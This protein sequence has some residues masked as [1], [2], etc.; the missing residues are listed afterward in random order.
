M[1]VDHYRLVAPL[2]RSTLGAIP[3]VSACYHDGIDKSETWVGALRNPPHIATVSVP[4]PSGPQPYL[5]LEPTAME[6]ATY[7]LHAVE[8]HSWSCTPNDPERMAFARILL[9]SN[10]N[11]P[12][13]LAAQYVRDAL[14]VH[15]LQAIP[16]FDGGGGIALWVPIDDAPAY[17]PVRTWLHTF[18][19]ALA[20]AHPDLI[21]TE[22]NTRGAHLVHLH[23]AKNAPRT[24]SVLP[25]S[26][27]ANP[28]YPVSF[29]ATWDELPTL[30]NGAFTIATL[31]HRLKTVGDLFATLRSSIPEQSFARISPI[32]MSVSTDTQAGPHHVITAALTILADGIPRS[33]EMLCEAAI[34][35]HL[36][37]PNFNP[38]YLYTAL[39]EYITRANGNARK[40]RILQNADRSF[41]L[42]EP[43]DDW[44][45]LV[46][47]PAA[48][49]PDAATLALIARLRATSTGGNPTAFE[50]AVCDTFSH[51]GFLA[52]HLG[53]EK[54]PDGYADAPLGILRYRLMIECK[55]AS[56]DV[57]QPN[58]FEASKYRDAYTAQ[59]CTLVGPAFANDTQLISELQTHNVS[60]WTVDDLATILTVNANPYEI[61]ALLAPGFAADSIVD[62]VWNRVHGLAKRMR[63]I[64]HLIHTEGWHFQ[65]SAIN[66]DPSV[67]APQI[68]IDV[69]LAL[70]DEALSNAGATH[71]CTRDEIIQAF[72]Y[73]TNPL[74]NIATSPTQN[75]IILT[76]SPC[77]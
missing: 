73:L 60:A 33:A 61:T 42:N 49:T 26:A 48:P 22:P 52:T 40:P 50:T 19:A 1:L 27:R 17:D 65:T 31:P 13:I 57:A 24:F 56:S 3:I 59:Y 32:V 5:A 36:L 66:D 14:N 39:I 20:V 44:P 70:V 34:A 9:E 53:G 45:D 25:Y 4:T 68:T 2:L 8:F 58:C 74:L 67:P 10:D 29:P 63:I 47:I 55:T 7:A 69:A 15:Q 6:W 41:R 71:G 46:P 64:T 38:K 21:T 23:V 76:R 11:A 18:A 62:L 16:V 35:A 30:H 28:H 72:A 77:G 43:P 12:L 54:A 75:S 51:L 37:A